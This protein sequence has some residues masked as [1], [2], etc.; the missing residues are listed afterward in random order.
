MDSTKE[1]EK[2]LDFERLGLPNR[3]R[4][5]GFEG[6]MKAIVK[7]GIYFRLSDNPIRQ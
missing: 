4:T 1:A 7:S 6:I 2:V 5:N 3:I